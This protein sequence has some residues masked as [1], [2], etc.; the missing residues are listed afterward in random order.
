MT[1]FCTRNISAMCEV[2]FLLF[3][4]STA[5]K[6]FGRNLTA[7]PVLKST[8]VGKVENPAQMTRFCTQNIPTMF[9]VQFLFLLSVQLKH[10]CRVLTAFLLPKPTRVG[11]VENQTQ[12]TQFCTQKIP[13]LFGVQFLLFLVSTAE[14]C[15]SRILMSF[16]GLDT[17]GTGLEQAKL[18]TELG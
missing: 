9:G 12:I 8:R 16:L 2:Q 11:K 7:F 10:F 5:K 4:V 15:F 14:E 13:T 1:R 17:T 18:E 6:Y 3:V